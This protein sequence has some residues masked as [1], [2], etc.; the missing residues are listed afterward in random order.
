MSLGPRTKAE[1]FDR[2]GRLRR[3]AIDGRELASLRRRAPR[4]SGSEKGLDNTVPG[5]CASRGIG[6]PAI[7]AKEWPSRQNGNS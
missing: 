2:I 1:E 3:A 7:V 6:T 5:P 4:Q